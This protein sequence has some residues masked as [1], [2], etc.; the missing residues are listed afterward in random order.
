MK[1]KFKFL[2][3]ACAFFAIAGCSKTNA[4]STSSGSNNSQTSTS[5]NSGSD[6]E[7][8]NKTSSSGTSDKASSSSSSVATY[9]PEL[10]EFLDNFKNYNVSI[11]N[12]Y[13]TLDFYSEK[14]LAYTS[15]GKNSN[16]PATS[17]FQAVAV[18][19]AGIWSW[20]KDDKGN[21][22]LGEM[23]FATTAYDDMT[24]IYSNFY[25]AI[26]SF[27][28][29][30]DDWV[31]GTSNG[32]YTINDDCTSGVMSAIP[33]L[34]SYFEG[35]THAVLG[36]I[37][38]IT[39]SKVKM[40]IKNQFSATVSFSAKIEGKKNGTLNASFTISNAGANVANGLDDFVDDPDSYTVATN[41]SEDV[42]NAM[43]EVLG[44]PLAFTGWTR[45]WQYSLG[46][47]AKTKKYTTIS[48]S[49][50]LSGDISTTLANTLTTAGYTA[51][52]PESSDGITVYSYTKKVADATDTLGE[53]TATIQYTYLSKTSLG[54]SASY[55]PNGLMRLI[56]SYS[57]EPIY[58]LT[59]V[60]KFLENKPLKK[61][62]TT[63]LPQLDLASYSLDDENIYIIDNTIAAN[64]STS[65]SGTFDAYLYLVV[66][67]DSN[68]DAQA[69]AESY[70]SAMKSHNTSPTFK[71]S[72]TDT[73]E[74]SGVEKYTLTDNAFSNKLTV[75]FY[76]FNTETFT[77]TSPNG[78]LQ[79]VI[80][81]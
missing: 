27:A 28:Y 74:S 81:Y 79:I 52:T 77:T 14:A 7:I 37:T 67:F 19:D 80:S 60:N 33:A 38:S 68:D 72:G 71:I 55:Y 42:Q 25:D 29:S 58:G 12:T 70:I 4:D 32:S 10:S 50:L 73:L 46:T 54:T 44:S 17:N 16:Y 47:D 30:E 56:A 22:E 78:G 24:L 21:F 61:D 20:S 5:S 26:D 41:F 40:T 48:Y 65:I 64:A 31:K 13:Y 57:Y 11:T 18:G 49:D 1:N 51:G 59:K 3:L 36:S 8:S 23:L 53:K 45:G 62:G 43:T 39:T 9:I 75:T 15:T 69:A 35:E 63:A 34:A 2:S 76:L 66:L 6:Q